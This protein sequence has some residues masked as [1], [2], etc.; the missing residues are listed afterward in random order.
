MKNLFDN[1]VEGEV[2][3]TTN[4]FQFISTYKFSCHSVHFYQSGT[5]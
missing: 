2:F 1:L 5:E 4:D 3:E